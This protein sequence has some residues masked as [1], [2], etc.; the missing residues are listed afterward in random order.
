[1][2][3]LDRHTV[4]YR[5]DL[6]VELESHELPSRIAIA[7]HRILARWSNLT[8]TQRCIVLMR[9]C[10]LTIR[11]AEMARRLGIGRSG[12]ANAVKSLHSRMPEVARA[13]KL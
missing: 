5:D 11:K 7:L 12:V 2:D 1:M 3:A 13:L 6:G 8:E 9:S 4:L 10:D